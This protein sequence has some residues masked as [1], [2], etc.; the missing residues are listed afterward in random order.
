MND[1]GFKASASSIFAS[2]CCFHIVRVNW[3][4]GN[5]GTLNNQHLCLEASSIPIFTVRRLRVTTNLRLKFKK[6]V[7]PILLKVFFFGNLGQNSSPWATKKEGILTSWKSVKSEF[8][9]DD[10]MVAMAACAEWCA[11]RGFVG[12]GGVLEGWITKL[13]VD[14][15]K[16]SGKLTSWYGKSPTIRSVSKT[17]QR[18]LPMEFQKNQP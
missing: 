1:F 3:H 12:R 9:W 16:K 7:K 15:P 11:A 2:F 14:G 18:R 5:V 17:Y 13:T 8:R 4:T 10:T 6:C